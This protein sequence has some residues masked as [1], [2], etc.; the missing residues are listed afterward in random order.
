VA[1]GNSCVFYDITTGTNAQVC[2]TGSRNCVTNTSGDALGV[3]SG[4]NSTTG[5]DLTTGLGSVNA[6]N[7]VEAWSS[8]VAGPTV[9]LTPTPLTFASTKVGSTSAAQTAT[10]KNTSTSAALTITS[11]GITITGTDA[12]S[13]IKTT[14]CGS[15][16]A[17]GA[18]CT[19]SVSFKPAATGT[20]TATLSVADNAT[21][22]P[23]KVSLTG[24]GAAAPT[25]SITLSPTT[26][27]FPTTVVAATSEAQPVTVKNTGTAT[28]TLTK[29]ALAGASPAS[30]EELNT[31]P[32][33]LAS[34][35]S[36]VVFVAFKPASA[37]LLKATLDVT[38]SAA[39]SP[40]AATLSGTGTA[41]I[42]VTLSTK[43]LAFPSTA[44]GV[45]SATKSVTVTNRGASALAITGIAI[46]GL[47][48]S[49]FIQ[50]NDCGQ[51]LAPA[52]SCVIAVAFKPATT[53]SISASLAV[54]DNGSSSPQTVSLTGTGH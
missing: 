32:A 4:Y 18:S 35:A 7:L 49:S 47:E 34:G 43:T 54:A 53:G 33:T 11:G 10:L 13:F 23:Q 9:T 38:D 40:Q 6:Y 15:S 30:Y 17:A 5:Y 44:K 52:A 8:E 31:C 48:A 41:A 51:S 37:A 27:A 26:L 29:I 28:V 20:L 45:Q 12:S 50:L 16:L 42:S 39:G 1:N 25:N 24:T 2:T 22:S 21:G 36:C 3:V 14:T 46:T 19:I